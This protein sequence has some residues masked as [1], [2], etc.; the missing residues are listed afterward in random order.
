MINEGQ[1]E[2]FFP[3]SSFLVLIRL[4]L[5]LLEEDLAT[6]VSVSVQH[7]S[8]SLESLTSLNLQKSSSV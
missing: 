4:R 5:G 1:K 6:R 2:H 8:M 3:S 7:I